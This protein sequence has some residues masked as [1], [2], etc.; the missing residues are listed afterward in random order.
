MAL[1]IVFMGTP[2]FSVP[3]LSS[4]L[5]AGHD[6]V[7]V[8]CQPPRPGGRRGLV[9]TKSP[10]HAFAEQSGIRVHFPRTLKGPEAAGVFAAQAADVAVVVAYGLILPGSIL[11][12]P[13]FGCV[14]LH[15]SKLPRWRGAAPIQRAIM[16]GDTETA[17]M[18]MR[19]EAGLDTGP[20]GLSEL[21]SIGP[22]TTFGQLHDDLAN[23]GAGLMV[24]ALDALE[25]GRLSFSAQSDDGVTY[26]HKIDKGETRLDFSSPATHVHNLIRGLSPAPGAWFEVVREGATERVKVLRSVLIGEAG[27]HDAALPGTV[28][29]DN[30]T[31][32]CGEGMVRLLQL[33]RA[34]KRPSTAEEFLRGFPIGQGARL[35]QH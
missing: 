27:A 10:V 16:A 9:E 13:R 33:Q 2:A 14:N 34:G 5:T 18:V 12:I 20:V 32:A 15:A 21:V 29:D 26:A 19:M 8:Y 11:E 25:H 24:R 22:N 1:K 35:N 30:L 23:V 6:V 4:I 28:L 17:V 3:T 31:I 7:G